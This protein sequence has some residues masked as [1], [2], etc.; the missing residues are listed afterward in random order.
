MIKGIDVHKHRKPDHPIEDLF[1]RRW[2]PRAMSGEAVDRKDLMR[3]FEAAR[4]APSSYNG[5]QW[6]FYYAFKGT[7]HWDSFYG[8]MI[9]FNQQW[10]AKAGVLIVV[11]SRTTF[12]HNDKPS[13]THSFDTGAAWQNLAL[14][15]ATMNLVVHAMQGFDYD[16]ARQVL[17]LPDHIAV[18]AM[19]AV[20]HPGDPAELPEGMR[21]REVPSGRKPVAEIAFEG[22]HRG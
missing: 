5:Q 21:E 16:K 14:Q 18:E 22:P 11:C 12:E 6:R 2:S 3:L 10:T 1:I 4:W 20:G 9:E 13:H 8:L 19:V 15:G 17:K 7:P